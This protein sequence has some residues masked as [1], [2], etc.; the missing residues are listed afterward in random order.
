MQVKG[1]ADTSSARK[2]GDPFGNG[3]AKIPVGL[4]DA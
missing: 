2:G 3:A 1:Q 4:E